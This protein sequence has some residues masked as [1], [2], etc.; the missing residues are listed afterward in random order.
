MTP[1]FGSPVGPP[2]VS[3][4]AGRQR[5]TIT[6][7]I[8]NADGDLLESGLATL[9]FPTSIGPQI[10]PINIGLGNPMMFSPDVVT[11]F[12]EAT[13]FQH[14]APGTQLVNMTMGETFSTGQ[15]Y[16]LRFPTAGRYRKSA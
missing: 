3:K 12:I 2:Q 5:G 9:E 14:V 16:A 15:P 7:R 13:N 1:T 8:Y 6:V 10:S 4:R 11:D